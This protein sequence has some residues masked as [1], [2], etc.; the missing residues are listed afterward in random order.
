MVALG[1]TVVKDGAGT[2]I[3]GGVQTLTQ[4]DSTTG[5]FTFLNVMTDGAT[6]T[7]LA[8]IK[9][10]NTTAVAGDTGLVVGIHPQSNAV[11]ASGT[12]TAVVEGV[13]AGDNA[14]GV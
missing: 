9:K 8:T 12:V 4:T 5:P 11:V 2:N 1:T 14:G 7:T 3:P 10:A 13:A 6:G